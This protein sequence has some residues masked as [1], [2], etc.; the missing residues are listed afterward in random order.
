MASVIMTLTTYNK[1]E[2]AILPPNFTQF[3]P[4]INQ[5]Q[6]I[7]TKYDKTKWKIAFDIY[8]KNIPAYY[9]DYIISLLKFMKI[10]DLTLQSTS[11]L[12]ASQYIHVDQIIAK[13]AGD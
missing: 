11:Q 7:K 10:Y 1:L 2:V 13:I 6:T 3:F 5:Y 8:M 9:N 4:L 12:Y